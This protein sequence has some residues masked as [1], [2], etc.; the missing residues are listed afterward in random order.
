MDVQEISARDLRERQADVLNQ[1]V[2]KG[3]H[4]VITRHGKEA[5]V[6]I[7][8][9]EFLI[10]QKAMEYLEDESDVADA[11]KAIKE[12]KRQ[13]SKPLKQLAKELGISV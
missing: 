11:K 1:I 8:P 9:D 2:F 4:F 5:A 3:A 7:S 13:G 10:L 6:L 12:V